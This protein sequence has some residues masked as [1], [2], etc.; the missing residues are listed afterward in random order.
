[1]DSTT[2][3]QKEKI[4]GAIHNYV[5][6]WTDKI[7]KVN[8]DFWNGK[9]NS[10][11]IILDFYGKDNKFV[12][13]AYKRWDE[14]ELYTRFNHFRQEYLSKK[15]KIGNVAALVHIVESASGRKVF[16]SIADGIVRNS[17]TMGQDNYVEVIE[18]LNRGTIPLIKKTRYGSMQDSWI[19]E[20]SSLFDIKDEL[21]EKINKMVEKDNGFLQHNLGEIRAIVDV[22]NV[23]YSQGSISNGT[24]EITEEII[25]LAEQMDITV[26]RILTET[27]LR[28]TH[29]NTIFA[30]GSSI[31]GTQVDDEVIKDFMDSKSVQ[32]IGDVKHQ[33]WTADTLE[34]I[35]SS[36]VIDNPELK[37]LLLL[38]SSQKKEIFEL[39]NISTAYDGKG[40]TNDT[41][42][43]VASNGDAQS[44]YAD[45]KVNDYTM[46]MKKLI[47]KIMIFDNGFNW[48]QVDNFEAMVQ[49]NDFR[50]ELKNRELIDKD[51]KV[52]PLSLILTR[53]FGYNKFQANKM[54]IDME[55]SIK[56]NLSQYAGIVN[57]NMQP[58]ILRFLDT[59]KWEEKETPKNENEN[60][61][62]E[63]KSKN[64]VEK[65]KDRFKKV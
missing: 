14:I 29:I 8:W 13:E 38:L 58:E 32:Y 36:I 64:I 33:T 2:Q 25:L 17:D 37:Q 49:S 59:G 7:N 60:E 1:M 44:S 4:T 40:K 41:E 19:F 62:E 52:I 45:L 28:T 53:T 10:K 18:N 65:I 55:T 46:F 54:V 35:D 47:K 24:P 26:S 61:N 56:D 43:E 15:L 31:G 21:R 51:I 34:N 20:V 22:N 57:G 50:R 9:L 5:S 3:E 63:G 11:P 42:L 6:V 30:Q 23:G 48:E 27:I 12:E 16:L 39:M